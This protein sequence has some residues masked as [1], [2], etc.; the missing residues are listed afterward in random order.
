MW[1]PGSPSFNGQVLTVPEAMCYPRPLQDRVP[2]LVGGN[3]ERLTLRL[4]ARYADACN[5]MGDLATV[6]RKADVLRQHCLAV[7]RDPDD[8]AVTHLTTSLIG[9]NDRD[10]SGVVERMRPRSRSA[11]S[12]AAFVHAGTV[13]DQVGRFR[14]LAEAGVREVMVR[15][16]NLASDKGALERMAKVIAAFR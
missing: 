2:L 12:Y 11:E 10:V 6:R 16:P 3:G 9:D 13:E 1:G 14:A 4:A 5:V 15:L 7:G 8:V